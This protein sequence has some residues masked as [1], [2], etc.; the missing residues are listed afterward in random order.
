MRTLLSST[1]QLGSSCKQAFRELGRKATRLAFRKPQDF[2]A[3]RTYRGP[4]GR[5]CRGI[6]WATRCTLEETLA[7]AV[8]SGLAVRQGKGWKERALRA[9]VAG[10]AVGHAR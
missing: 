7:R 4:A 1:A 10:P 8:R 3:D 6:Q 5:L 9:S 2:A